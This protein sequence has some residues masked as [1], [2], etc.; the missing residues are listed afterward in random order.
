MVTEILDQVDGAARNGEYFLALFGALALPS[1]CSALESANGRDSR[2]KYE[3][4]FDKWVGPKYSGRLT[5]RQCYSFRCAMLHQGRAVHAGLGYDRVLF[6]EP[7]FAAARG[8]T[9]HNNVLNGALNLD[10]VTFCSDVT[11][12]ARDWLRTAQGSARY[13]KNIDRSF[14]RFPN[15]FPPFIVGAPVVTSGGVAHPTPASQPPAGGPLHGPP[16]PAPAAPGFGLLLGLT[17]SS[18]ER[19]AKLSPDGKPATW[20]SAATRTFVEPF[21]KKWMEIVADGQAEIVDSESGKTFVAKK[22]DVPP[23]MILM[24]GPMETP[25]TWLREF[26]LDADLVLG[27]QRAFQLTVLEDQR[28]GRPVRWRTV[29]EMVSGIAEA[30][31]EGK[32]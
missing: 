30:A 8:W 29:N 1:I 5:G 17:D 11:N 26:R 27:I 32:K 14:R 25:P 3:R 18:I 6:L 4:W 12:G 2:D 24:F 15:G 20:I 21:L 13:L 16:V 9:F 28:L 31:L 7:R 23:S 10:L 22:D 19:A